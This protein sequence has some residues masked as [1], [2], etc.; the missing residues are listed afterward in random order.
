MNTADFQLIQDVLVNNHTFGHIQHLMAKGTTEWS[1]VGHPGA[2]P[3]YVNPAS[4][5][6]LWEPDNRSTF[7]AV[8]ANGIRVVRDGTETARFPM[9]LSRILYQAIQTALHSVA[10]GIRQESLQAGFELTGDLLARSSVGVRSARFEVRVVPCDNA[11]GKLFMSLPSCGRKR[12]CI[13]Q[14]KDRAGE[15]LVGEYHTHPGEIRPL[16]HIRPPSHSDVVRN[17]HAPAV[18]FPISVCS[19]H[20]TRSTAARR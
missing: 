14:H 20:T 15:E 17:G 4:L 12:K 11:E 8:Y 18:P 6:S 7:V 19:P 3:V 2:I 16:G 5:L 1:E 9:I 13:Q 10:A